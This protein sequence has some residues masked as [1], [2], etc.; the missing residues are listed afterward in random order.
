MPPYDDEWRRDVDVTLF[1]DRND[2][3][4]RPGLIGRVDRIERFGSTIVT[5]LTLLC[6]LCGAIVAMM[7]LNRASGKAVISVTQPV[8]AQ[9]TQDA[10][11]ERR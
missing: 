7:G 6:L 4:A 11:T 8:V 1:G 9:S 10:F 3:Q 5:L 2:M